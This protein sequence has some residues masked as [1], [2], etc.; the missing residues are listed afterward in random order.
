MRTLLAGA[1]AAL[2]TT[3]TLTAVP[4]AGAIDD[5]DSRQVEK[6][7][8]YACDSSLG[9]GDFA[10]TVSTSLPRTHEAGTKLAIRTVGFS[11]VVPEDL[12]QTMRD[13]GVEE[14]SGESKD[15]TW[16]I[17]AKVRDIRDLKLPST[18]VPDEG[19]LVLS[20]AGTAQAV[21]LVTPK[22]YPVRLPE[23]FSAIVSTTGG[24]ETTATITCALADGEVAR[25]AI[26]KVV[27]AGA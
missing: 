23:T 16:S 9:S 11:I 1:V 26:L 22:T 3:C 12:T 10:V 24:V 25:I 7:V 2:V 19:P 6:T 20:G 14:V 27:N 8:T 17:G 5:T 21:R 4:P 15:T 18:P 13:Y